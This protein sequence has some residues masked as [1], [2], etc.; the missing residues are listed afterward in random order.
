MTPKQKYDRQWRR[1]N[2]EKLREQDRKRYA[3]NPEKRIAQV[4]AWRERNPGYARAWHAEARQQQ[5]ET[6]AKVSAMKVAT[7]SMTSKTIR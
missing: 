7:V 2:A 3:A 6:D 5:I 1:D 4:R